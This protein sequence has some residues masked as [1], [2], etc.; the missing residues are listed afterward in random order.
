MART[1]KIARL[2]PDVFEEFNI[3]LLGN[4]QVADILAWVNSLPDV[5]AMLA[6]LFDGLPISDANVSIWR[7]DGGGHEE[8]K[9][10]R[11]KLDYISELAVLS[12]KLAERAG[13]R[14]AK[15]FLPVAVGEIHKALEAGQCVEV[16]EKGKPF[17]T[18]IGADKLAK[19]LAALA[20]IEIDEAKLLLDQQKH[21]LDRE[22]HGLNVKKF[23]RDSVSLF[24]EW[25]TD[26]KAKAIATSDMPSADKM[27]ALGQHLF[28]EAW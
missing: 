11:T 2:P 14:F 22:V 25:A 6:R 13:G 18:G 10:D 17:V 28:G 23:Q 27:E 9:R 26:E 8:W 7:Q 12:A 16:D 24:I 15:G 1:G 5:Q 20:K 3:R 21:A 4:P 19:A